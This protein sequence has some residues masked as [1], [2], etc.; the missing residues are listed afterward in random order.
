MEG[1][2]WPHHTYTPPYHWR[3]GQGSF[4]E[5]HTS[6]AALAFDIFPALLGEGVC[7]DFATAECMH[8]CIWE[9]F[10]CFMIPPLYPG[11]FAFSISHHAYSC[12]CFLL[13]ESASCLREGPRW[14]MLACSLLL[15]ALSAWRHCSFN[16]STHGH[17]K[18]GGRKQHLG[19]IFSCSLGGMF[20][21]G[22]A[23]TAIWH[24]HGFAWGNIWHAL[25]LP[26]PAARRIV[27]LVMSVRAFM[28]MDGAGGFV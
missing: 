28:D 11:F 26:W 17:M 22:M 1:T 9:P 25:R 18:G 3:L 10:L 12:F 13:I 4:T 14:R 5:A 6:P 2:H 19:G 7:D 8:G 23:G 16:N 21:S 20:W 15:A 24:H 27:L